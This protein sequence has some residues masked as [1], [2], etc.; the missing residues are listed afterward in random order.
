M[1]RKDAK[2]NCSRPA[3]VEEKEA[4]PIK[5]FALLWK[6]SL[7]F[8]ELAV[9]RTSP[10]PVPTLGSRVA[11]YRQEWVIYSSQTYAADYQTIKY[12]QLCVGWYVSPSAPN[13]S[14]SPIVEGGN[15][16]FLLS[17]SLSSTHFLTTFFRETELE[18]FS[19][20]VGIF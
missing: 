3:V 9:H 11:E 17:W 14:W 10:K 2:G 8:K 1:L 7:L 18:V 20:L 12:Q 19:L 5:L 16:W 13:R 6:N 15:L 4:F